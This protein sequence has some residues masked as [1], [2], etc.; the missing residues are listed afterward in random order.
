MGDTVV[1][2]LV[3][4]PTIFLNEVTK[5]QEDTVYEFFTDK[6]RR[7]GVLLG[8]LVPLYERLGLELKGKI[9]VYAGEMGEFPV[10]FDI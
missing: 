4:E 2:A 6:D 7:L 3:Y 8:A 1:Y 10:C 5:G 9:Q